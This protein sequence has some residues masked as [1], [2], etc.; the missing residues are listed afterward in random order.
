MEELMI[1]KQMAERLNSFP[2]RKKAKQLLA[3]TLAVL[4]FNPVTNYGV[5]AHAQEPEAGTPYDIS[6]GALTINSGNLSTYDNATIVGTVSSDAEQLIIDGGKVNLTIEDLSITMTGY[7]GNASGITL[8]HGATLN[9]TVKGA[10]TLIGAYGGAGIDVPQGCT[11]NIM[12]ESTGTLTA[13]GGN[14][15]GGGAGIGAVGNQYSPSN[16]LTSTQSVGTIQIAGGTIIAIGGS[17]NNFGAGV[18]GAAGIGGSTESTTG[19][20]LISGGTVIATGGYSAAGIGG[21]FCGR[22]DSVTIEGGMVT[23]IRGEGGS[24]IGSGYNGIASDNEL[25]LSCGMIAINGGA[26]AVDGNIGYGEAKYSE[27]NVGGTVSIGSSAGVTIKNCVISPSVAGVTTY[28]LSITIYDGR[29]SNSIAN[30]S[31][32]IG[33]TTYQGKI[34]VSEKY[35]GTLTCSLVVVNGTLVGDQITT[36]TGGGYSWANISCLKNYGNYSAEIGEKLYPV[37]L[38]F[39]DLAITSDIIGAT[40]FVK[41]SEIPLNADAMQGFVHLVCDGTITKQ[42]DGVGKMTVW[43]TPGSETDLTA[44]VS[45]LIS[46]NMMS[47]SGQTIQALVD[48]TTIILHDTGSI[49]Q[50]SVPLDLSY[51]NITFKENGGTLDIT[52]TT[53]NGSTVT[54]SGQYYQNEYEIIQTNSNTA[55]TNQIL[56]QNTTDFVKVTLNGVNMSSIGSAIE[57]QTAKAQLNLSGTNIIDCRGDNGSPEMND[58]G[59]HAGAGSELTIDGSGSLEVKN[60]SA[61]GV[62]IGGYFIHLNNYPY[63]QIHEATGTIRI[64]GG[65][66][67]VAGRDGAA[68]GSAA[69]YKD[70]NPGNIEISGGTVIATNSGNGTAIGSGDNGVCPNITITGGTVIVN[71]IGTNRENGGGSLAITG[72]TISTESGE[73]PKINVPTT[74]GSG[75][76]VY[77]T[78]ANVSAFYG[79]SAAVTNASVTDDSYGFNDVKTDSSGILHLFLPVSADNTKTT[80]VFNSITYKGI[81]SSTEPNTLRKYIPFVVLKDTVTY[82][83]TTLNV[84]TN[85]GNTIYYVASD[86]ML[87][88]GSLLASAS[89]VKSTTMSSGSGTITLSGLAEGT[90]YTYYFTAKEGDYYSDVEAVTFTTIPNAPKASDVSLDYKNELLMP[91]VGLESTLEYALTTDAATWMKVTAVGTSLTNLLDNHTGIETIPIYIRMNVDGI[92]S[93]PTLVLIP[94]RPNCSVSTLSINY[95][96]ESVT[97]PSSVWYQFASSTPTSWAYVFQGSDG[98]MSVKDRIKAAGTDESNLNKIYFRN[99]ATNSAFASKTVCVVIPARPEIPST[100]LAASVTDTEIKLTAVTGAEY[101]KDFS[102]W[103]DSPVFSGLKANRNYFF[104]QRLKATNFNFA[105]ETSFASITTAKDSIASATVTLTDCDSFV[106]DGT[107]KTPTVTVILNNTEL[108]SSQYTVSYSNS[109]GGEGNHANAGTVTVTVTASSSG[110]YSGTISQTYT[111]AKATLTVDDVIATSRPYNGTK[112]VDITGVTLSGILSVDNGKVSVD[113]SN[114]TGTLNGADAGDYDCVTLTNALT[115]TGMAAGNYLLTQPTEA[116]QKPVTI[117]KASALSLI[118]NANVMK[119]QS[120]Y[121][122]ELD[123]TQISG[124]PADLSTTPVFTVTSGSGY[125]GLTSVV[126]NE[127]GKLTLIADNTTNGTS[128]TITVNMTGM[129]N[130]KDSIITMT[131]NYTDKTTVTINGVITQNGTY[132]GTTQNGYIGTPHSTYLGTYDITY[133][134]RNDTTYNSNI[135]PV[136]AGDY[137]VNFKVPDS[138]LTYTGSASL[139]FQIGKATIIATANN[140]SMTASG[141]L[142]SFTVS[143]TGI[144]AGDTINSIFS[145]PATA[146]T[147]TDGKTDGN[148]TITVTGPVLTTDAANNYT[149]GTLVNGTLTVSTPPSGG[150]SST[151]GGTS[152]GGNTGGV[153]VT[154]PIATPIITPTITPTVTPTVTP[155][156]MPNQPVSAVTPVTATVGTNGVASALIPDQAVIDAIAQ[157]QADAKAQ[158]KT[159]DG[160]SVELDITVPKRATSLSAVLTRSSLDRMI[161]DGVD[162]LEING[163]LHKVSFDKKALERIQKQSKGN[164]SITIAAKRNLSD[165]AKKIISTRPVYDITVGY[166]NGKSVSGLGGGIA[167]VSMQYTPS[168]G[169]AVGGLYA[170]Y[171]D[172]NGNA[173]RIAGSAYDANSRCVI[174]TTTHLSQYGIG[175]TAPTV[176]FTDI[177]SH[178]AKESIDYVVGRGLI[179][180]TTKTVFSPNSAMTRGMLLMA[181][182]KLAG[183]DIKAYTTNSFIDVKAD[184]AYRPYIE[185][186]YKKGILTGISNKKFA[187]NRVITHEELAAIF[188]NYARATGYTLPIIREATTYADASSIDTAYKDGVKAMQQAGI[189]M[190]G[191]NN[192][193][194]PKRKATRAEVSSM[195]NRYIKLTISPDTALGWAQNDD[196]QYLYYKDGSLAKNTKIDGYEV[197]A[198]GVRKENH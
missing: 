94:T 69:L 156:R 53:S 136:N 56:V 79:T 146:S 89:G 37:N 109:N 130:Y 110:N 27:K 97:I 104:T 54:V 106:Y 80:A 111:I 112:Q 132:N 153:E 123:L 91:A 171:V 9:L 85:S 148:Y 139:D 57:L 193:F 179:S 186:A 149:V 125:N 6:T 160:I 24:A 129:K 45:G 105:S 170:V 18:M 29:L 155:E 87:S 35:V 140:K 157:A 128:D 42:R 19:V 144:V 20:I 36:V 70:T 13:T 61:Y 121:T 169:E 95:A 197:D 68:I 99:L 41:R 164:I 177:S 96:N 3:V 82:T 145:T 55:T 63:T 88:E 65:T 161:S 30:A 52:Y 64:Q 185:W 127:S 103:Q 7:G 12:S 113:T 81:I 166:G 182:G 28:P 100:P 26:V 2:G 143:Y 124:Y 162:S 78:R 141:V 116:I 151:G 114:L 102:N 38:W 14:S 93:E 137:T 34:N 189:M 40:V 33:G 107:E 183:V 74:N 172:E 48:G 165:T 196:G 147:T 173:T 188:V 158:G 181:L 50:L 59:I 115:L 77:Y 168:K 47:K 194:N 75:K 23:A 66:L 71:E 101:N 154:T 119:K 86:A 167:S 46:G 131:V 1:I 195:L 126:V 60:P 138:H 118:S 98:P 135:A 83:S 11:L 51:G 174:F 73:K 58:M 159:A 108:D 44:T 150:G 133:T 5:T 117:T 10:N 72:G 142:P 22:V 17:S 62:G 67:A 21:G 184:N 180:G 15:Y 4:M 76:A 31:F 175:Y 163:P 191:S 192:Q 16:N 152:S 84:T 32:T 8:K 176:K 49:E 25:S 122:I 190:G 90:T 198:N 92:Y 178:W 187:P 134:G 120:N 39:Y 43:M